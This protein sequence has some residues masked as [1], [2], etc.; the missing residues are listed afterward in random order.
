MAGRKKV[1]HEYN[2]SFVNKREIK[3]AY[4]FRE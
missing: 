1:D 3:G 2:Q 4:I